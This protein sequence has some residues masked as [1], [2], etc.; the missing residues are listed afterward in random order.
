MIKEI[1]PDIIISYPSIS[2]I[3]SSVSEDPKDFYYPFIL[4]LEE[5]AKNWNTLTVNFKF[6]YYNTVSYMYLTRIMK[7]LDDMAKHKEVLINWYY[8]EKDEKLMEIGEDL[9]ETYKFNI[10]LIKR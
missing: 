5:I 7:I 8:L 2:I 10:K 3:G 9:K 4:Q 6:D 1:F